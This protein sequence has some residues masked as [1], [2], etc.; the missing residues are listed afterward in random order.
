MGVGFK[1]EWVTLGL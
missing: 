1:T